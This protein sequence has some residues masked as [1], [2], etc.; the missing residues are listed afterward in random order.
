MDKIIKNTAGSFFVTNNGFTGTIDTATR[1]ATL[2]AAQS[3][4]ACLV[5]VGLTGTI[6]NSPVAADVAIVQ[7]S[8]GTSYAVSYIRSKDLDADGSI[9]TNKRNPSP[10]RFKTFA[11]AR[12][13]ATRAVDH[14]QHSGYYISKTYAPVNAY[15]NKITGL[16]NPEIGKKRVL[17]AKTA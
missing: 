12:I 10:R 17:V 6:E 7:N 13:H 2:E 4:I 15:V 8:D 1:F 3:Q 11:E 14:H 16:T 9:K 5:S